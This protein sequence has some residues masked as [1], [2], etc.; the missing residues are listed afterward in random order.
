MV[1]HNTQLQS[2]VHDLTSRFM[3]ATDNKSLVLPLLTLA[4]A[5]CLA[6]CAPRTPE[7]RPTPERRPW[8]MFSEHDE[9]LNENEDALMSVEAEAD[10][11]AAAAEAGDE[12][13]LRSIIED[14]DV[15]PTIVEDANLEAAQDD[16]PKGRRQMASRSLIWEH[17]TK[18]FDD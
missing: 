14:E 18:V 2:L 8:P 6:R 4:A 17:F 11:E 10:E 5:C 9:E 7:Q 3:E 13:I 1:T 15:E 12:S 16:K